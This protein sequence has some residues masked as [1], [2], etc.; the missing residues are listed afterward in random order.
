MKKSILSIFAMLLCVCFCFAG[1]GLFPENKNA[2]SN[3]KVISSEKVTLTREEFVKGYNNYYSTFYN[4]SNGDSNK[5]ISSLIEYLVAKKLYIEDAKKLVEEG[6][7]VLSNTEKNYLWNTTYN[8]LISNI[9]SFEKEVKKLLNK[10]ETNGDKSEEK[11]QE[12]QFVYTPY[13]KKA[14][15]VFNETTNQYEIK[16]VKQILIRKD[17]D[18][19]ENYEY[20]PES[21]I[22]SY[23]DSSVAVYKIEYIYNKLDKEKYFSD[24]ETLTDEEK[25]SKIISKEAVRRYIEKLKKNEE[26]KNLSTSEKDVI[27]REVERIYGILYD[28]M[29]ITKLYEY[30][31]KDITISEEDFLK[32]YLSKV[33]GSY[34]RYFKDDE[35]FINELTK[36]VGS[37]N[38]YGNYSTPSKSISDVFY[39]PKTTENFFY[40]THI[41]VKFT[42]IQIQKINEL[43][44]FCEANG[45]D[46]SYYLSEYYKIVPNVSE[47]VISKVIDEQQ[48]F[49]NG[50]ITKE[51]YEENLL[52]IIGSK[53]LM[54]NE[55]DSEGYV[56]KDVMTVQEMIA[57]LYKDLADIYLKYKGQS[58]TA[59]TLNGKEY[60]PTEDGIITKAV[61]E[62]KSQQV[63]D[64][65]ELA[66]N[67]ERADKFNEYIYKYSQDT[68]TI[69]IQKSYFGTTS[70]NWY[71]YAMGD[72]DTDNG[73]VKSFT[74]KAR[75]LF[76]K[77]NITEVDTTIMENWKTSENKDK[78]QSG[79]TG[80]SVMMYAGKVNNLFECFDNNKFTI[81]DLFAEE[82]NNGNA[83]FYSLVKMTQYRLGL[84]MNKTLFDLIFEDYYNSLYEEKINI[85]EKEVMKDIDLTPN[86]SVIK[87]LLG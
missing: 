83:K 8:S 66:F 54:V 57:S 7:I 41:V 15:V 75:E 49:K 29:L 78:L 16:I 21:E 27:K 86:Q 17:K 35:A 38:L 68:G 6:K 23:N 47:S 36:T 10:E 85:Y 64:E 59:I 69:Q 50:T 48:K 77:G 74:E 30:K 28:N 44:E 5:A 46:E 40:V 52:T 43:K 32:L 42:D 14:E 34:D 51:Q 81:D 19:K 13:E 58:G 55:R 87:D 80:Y 24:K 39:V 18:G 71:L 31:T 26:G 3:Q 1:C 65:L 53:L 2:I 62:G 12:S 22:G 79:S 67:N 20:V 45:K 76:S 61:S 9:E 82:T 25:E 11:T 56:T 63:L 70:E 4:Q 84:T 33:K 37:A 60:T 72:K 73:F